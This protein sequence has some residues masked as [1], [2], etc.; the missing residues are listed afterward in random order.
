MLNSSFLSLDLI[1]QL[2]LVNGAIDLSKL[3]PLQGGGTHDIY[4]VDHKPPFL[5]KVIRKTI[6]ESQASLKTT[7]KDLTEKYEKLYAHFGENRCLLETRCIHKVSH[8]GVNAK[9]A[10]ISLV[11][12][13]PCF[14]NK[15][16]FGF[17]TQAVETMEPK[18]KKEKQKYHAMNASLLGD[19]F[20]PFN[21]NDFLYFHDEFEKVFGLL[22]TEPSLR[23]VMKEFL[24]KFKQYYQETDQLLDFTGLDNVVFYKNQDQ[25]EFKVGSVIKHE[26]GKRALDVLRTI[27]TTPS[28]V[29]ESFENWTFVYFVPS[30]LRLLNATGAKLGMSRVIENI[31]L[32]N[33]DSEH[34]SKMYEM[35]SDAERAMN[36][37][38]DGDFDSAL[39]HFKQHAQQEEHHD[40]RV[41]HMM[42]KYY[43]EFLKIEPQRQA[44][45]IAFMLNLISD[46]KNEYP[47]QYWQEA[48][49]IMLGLKDKLTAFEPIDLALQ[50]KLDCALKKI[51][52]VS[53]DEET[54]LSKLSSLLNTPASL[55]VTLDEP[56]ET[57]TPLHKLKSK[58][59]TA[60]ELNPTSSIAHHLNTKRK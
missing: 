57:V 14:K 23:E 60:V 42:C 16:K 37:A 47:K 28:L 10:I 40:T 41:R 24:T 36:N 53:T 15:H 19:S 49:S 50:Q 32:T 6:G 2:P 34:L 45:K 13:D 39:H 21:E 27:A 35:L 29:K 26:T 48:Q 55:I 18:L 43:L 30:W 51:G 25:W 38:Q 7:L 58:E 44:D 9:D 5:V 22:Q 20:A 3:T 8:D 17:N 1:N 52:Y 12:F 31:K 33:S 11:T 56:G 59:S 46:P 54:P 4:Q